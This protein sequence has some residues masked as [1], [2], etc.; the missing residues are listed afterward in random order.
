[1]DPLINVCMALVA[2]S[3][4]TVSSWH[5]HKVTALAVCRGT[6]MESSEEGGHLCVGAAWLAMGAG[7][8]SGW[9]EGQSQG[10]LP[11]STGQGGGQPEGT[12]AEQ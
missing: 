11:A 10:L 9:C 6:D 12:Q 7:L 3:G 5:S 8:T 2:A 4:V 1:M